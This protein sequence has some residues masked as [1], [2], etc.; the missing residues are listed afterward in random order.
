MLDQLDLLCWANTVLSKILVS[1]RTLAVA[2]CVIAEI[3]EATNCA[4]AVI[5]VVIVHD[6]P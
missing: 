4:T 6:I 5:K 2:V 1:K 3:G